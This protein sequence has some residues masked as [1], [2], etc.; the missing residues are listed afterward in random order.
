[1]VEHIHDLVDILLAQP[2]LV[3]ILHETFGGVDHEDARA[4]VG[5]LFVDDKDAGRNAG[6]VE[7]IAGQ[8]D[9]ALD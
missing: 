1:M 4:G 3:T 5:V 8:T 9:D 7:E 2:V 6:A